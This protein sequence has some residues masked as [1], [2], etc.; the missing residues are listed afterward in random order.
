MTD[1]SPNPSDSGPAM[2][3]TDLAALEGLEEK[4]ES[5]GRQAWNR[6]RRH[7]LAL[8]GVALLVLLIAAFWIGPLLSPYG[9]GET[10]VVDNN[11]GPSLAHPFGTDPLGRDYFVRAMTGGQFSIRIA[12]LTAGLATAIGL[13]IGSIAGYFGGL[14]DS[15]VG[16]L[17]NALLSVPAILV[18]VV[19]SR[20]V[21]SNPTMVAVL[22]AGLSWIRV[23]RLVRAQTLQLKEQEFVLAARSAG[24]G[25]FHIISR[26]LLPNLFSVLL[27]EVTLLVGTAIILESTLSF[28]GLGV[29]APLTTLGTIVADNK[30]AIDTRPSRVL[31]PGFI[32]TMIILSINFIGDA[33]RDAVDPKAGVE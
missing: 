28:L 15:V 20:R 8:V 26:H 4:P 5:L 31:I 10:N 30:G 2:D 18:L 11:Q 33:M 16:F 6:F 7:K 32:I 21:G 1:L 23:S 12:I 14:T 3:R 24:A 13:V 29:Q 17:V 25:P 19:F 27:V 9:V 22:I